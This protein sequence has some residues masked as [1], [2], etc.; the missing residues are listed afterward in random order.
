M[1]TKKDFSE[2]DILDKGIKEASFYKSINIIN[3][4]NHCNE[5]NKNNDVICLLCPHKCKISEGKRGI[6]RARLNIGGKL[7][8]TNYSNLCAFFVD[9]IEK[10]PMFHFIPSSKTLSVAI[11]GCNLKCLNC[12]NFEISLGDSKKTVIIKL[13]PHELVEE[14]IKKGVKIISYTYTEP[15]IFY[16]Y[17]IDT[18]KIAKRKNI[19]NII[20]SN[21]YINPKPLEELCSLL[22]GANID[23]K[24]FDEKGMQRL[25][26]G[27]IYP[28]LKSLKLIK[29]KKVF[30]EITN[31]IVPQYS[32]DLKAIKDMCKWIV[33]NLGKDTPIHFSAF[34]PTYKLSNLNVTPNELLK[35]ARKI[36]VDVG[37]NFVYIGNTR[38]LDAENTYCPSCKHI[39][40]ERK[41]Y[42]IYN[43]N[44]DNGKCNFCKQIIPGVWD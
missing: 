21:G 36:A 40:I 12:Q 28:V 37:L 9:P 18:A 10:K 13:T 29:S 3:K 30:L 4:I 34:Y 39:L 14:A 7:Y 32:D 22:D 26:S 43:N 41:G 24:C 5:F 27:S 44:I 6:C 19:K 23:L 11:A 31:L 33:K 1:N 20:V 15:T 42:Q 8:D 17:M 38:I 16:D 2:T 25:T 35:Q